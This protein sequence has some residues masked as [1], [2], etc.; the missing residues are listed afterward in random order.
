MIELERVVKCEDTR[1]LRLTST[2][3][4][5]VVA[6]P[7]ETVDTT[8]RKCETRLRRTADGDTLVTEC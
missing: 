1:Q 3:T 6:L 7:Q 8:D 2:D 5:S 4:L